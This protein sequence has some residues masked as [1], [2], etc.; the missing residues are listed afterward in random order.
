[1]AAAR[2]CDAEWIGGEW[3]V[4]EEFKEPDFVVISFY[5][6]WMYNKLNG[7]EIDRQIGNLPNSFGCKLFF[8]LVMA[9]KTV[10]A[11]S[12]VCG[13]NVMKE[14]VTLFSDISHND[15]E[16]WHSQRLKWNGWSCTQGTAALLILV[17]LSWSKDSAFIWMLFCKMM[18][19][20]APTSGNDW[21][22]WL[23]CSLAI[24]ERWST[25]P[26]SFLSFHF[27]TGL[28]MFF[29]SL[30]CFSGGYH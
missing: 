19:L 18:A 14:V 25:M 24:I 15:P 13:D 6:F 10:T 7:Q 9:T 5:F 3:C 11:W 4:F 2:I 20:C 1:M 26:F 22:W 27:I 21:W 23:I 17:G 30:R 28:V 8:L 29:P 16:C 12:A